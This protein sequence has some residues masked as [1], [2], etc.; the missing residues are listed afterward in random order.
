MLS[1]PPSRRPYFRFRRQPTRETF[2]G[3][4][5]LAPVLMTPAPACIVPTSTSAGRFMASLGCAVATN[6]GNKRT[7]S[8]APHSP[9]CLRLRVRRNK[10]ASMLGTPARA[11]ASVPTYD[12]HGFQFH[13]GQAQKWLNMAFKYVHVFGENRLPGFERHRPSCRA[14]AAQGRSPFARVTFAQR[15]APKTPQSEIREP[16]G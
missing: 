16:A 8:C 14:F 2:Y 1:T 9:N 7:S 4:C 12:E 6:S 5:I 11:N 3:A 10:A 15:Y 13:G